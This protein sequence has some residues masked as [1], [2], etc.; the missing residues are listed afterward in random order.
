MYKRNSTVESVARHFLVLFGALV[1]LSHFFKNFVVEAN[2][3]RKIIGSLPRRCPVQQSDV[4]RS[5]IPI[6]LPTQRVPF[7]IRPEE[8]IRSPGNGERDILSR[9]GGGKR[10]PSK[11]IRERRRQLH[12]GYLWH[13]YITSYAISL[14]FAGG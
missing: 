9:E 6:Q 10:S 5:R 3:A 2:A 8:P 12:G 1:S 13:G 4:R 11:R 7:V 14:E